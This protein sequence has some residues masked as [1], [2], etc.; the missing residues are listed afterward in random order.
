MGRFSRKMNRNPNNG[1]IGIKKQRKLFRKRVM[2]EQQQYWKMFTDG[3][4]NKAGEPVEQQE[5]T[6]NE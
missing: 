3:L 6:D 4:I 1:F 2:K 5:N